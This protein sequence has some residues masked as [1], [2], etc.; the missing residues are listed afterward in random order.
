MR[1]L[2]YARHGGFVNRLEGGL[3]GTRGIML[4]ACRRSPCI[5]TRV[6]TPSTSSARAVSCVQHCNLHL[7]LTLHSPTI[8]TYNRPYHY[9]RVPKGSAQSEFRE[10]AYFVLAYSSTVRLTLKKTGFWPRLQFIDSFFYSRKRVLGCLP[11]S[12]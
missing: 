7:V 10:E 2:Y 5:V 11:H 3:G 6:G 9:H 8:N 12:C 4:R 1:F